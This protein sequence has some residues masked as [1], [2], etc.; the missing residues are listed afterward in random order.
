[1]SEE[2]IAWIK[3]K[4]SE[5]EHLKQVQQTFLDFIKQNNNAFRLNSA[6]S[7]DGD[8][9]STTC[10]GHILKSQQKYFVSKE[11]ELAIEYAFYADNAEEVLLIWSFVLH[12]DKKI[13][14]INATGDFERLKTMGIDAPNLAEELSIQLHAAT[15]GSMLFVRVDRSEDH[16]S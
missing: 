6:F 1:M 10:F 2:Q 7:V 13:S 11:G 12:T 16:L 4:Q 9:L 15:F 3:T 8:D 5:I 14:F